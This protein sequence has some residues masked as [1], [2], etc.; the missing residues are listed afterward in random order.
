MS[1]DCKSLTD[2]CCY[3]YQAGVDVKFAAAQTV[4]LMRRHFHPPELQDPIL[5]HMIDIRD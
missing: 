1:F 5:L 2:L 4:E 3:S